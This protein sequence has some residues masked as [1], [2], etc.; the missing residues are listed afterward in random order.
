M[1]TDGQT[2][3]QADMTKLI[4]AFRN[5]CERSKKNLGVCRQDPPDLG[6]EKAMGPFEHVDERF[7][8]IKWGQ[9]LG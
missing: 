4:G 2:D 6:W 3:G 8:S 1:R 5:F 7:G 9:F